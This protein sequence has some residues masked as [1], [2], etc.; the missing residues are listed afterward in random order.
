MA[1]ET[2]VLEIKGMTCEE[3][4]QSITY[5]LKRAKGVQ[6]V[7]V[8]WRAKLGEVAFDPTL[9]GP[10]EIL[11]HPAFG[12]QFGAQLSSQAGPVSGRRQSGKRGELVAAASPGA[13]ADVEGGMLLRPVTAPPAPPRSAARPED[14]VFYRWV[15]FLS[16]G[17]MGVSLAVL[18]DHRVV[19]P[20][21]MAI[22]RAV[23]GTTTPAELGTALAL[24]LVAGASMAVTA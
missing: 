13:A 4:A 23:V 6:N 3:C 2:I 11:D 12:G 19:D 17:V 1:E 15:T 9:I 20:V 10:Q 16:A 7:K 24:A 8:D 5:S 21:A 14:A 18:W 22:Q